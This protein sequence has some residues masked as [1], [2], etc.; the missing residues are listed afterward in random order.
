MTLLHLLSMQIQPSYKPEKLKHEFAVFK[1]SFLDSFL[2]IRQ[3]IVQRQ[4]VC[5]DQIKTADVAD[6]L[7]T[8]SSV[9]VA[10]CV[11]PGIQMQYRVTN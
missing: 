10:T 9:I 11:H 7:Q 5:K 1:K 3:V 2:L 8:D 4:E 6:T